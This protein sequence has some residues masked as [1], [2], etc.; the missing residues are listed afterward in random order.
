MSGR[1]LA[2]NPA[3][4][5]LALAGLEMPD[6]RRHEVRCQLLGNRAQRRVGDD[7]DLPDVLV[8]IANEAEVS[9]HRAETVPSGKRLDL[10][11]DAGEIAVPCNVRVYGRR[12]L[13]E[14]RRGERG[15]GAQVE[16]GVRGVEPAFDHVSLLP[17]GPMIPAASPP[18]SNPTNLS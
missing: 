10:D 16:D 11:E 13:S 4:R 2:Q 18:A 8:V 7:R 17:R 1:S 14:I 15:L 9:R 12:E 3:L 6:R 5:R